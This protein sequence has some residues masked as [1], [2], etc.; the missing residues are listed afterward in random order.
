MVDLHTHSTASDGTLEPAELV[1]KAMDCGVKAL[2]L[3]DHDT[4][5]G[6]KEAAAQ[7]SELDMKFIPGIEISADFS[8]GTMHMLGYYVDADDSVLKQKLSWLREGR[9]R[10]NT[11]IL[12]MLEKQG[13]PVEMR[14]LEVYAKGESVGRPH[15]ARAMVAKGY[16]GNEE[17]AFNRFLAKGGPAY[18]NKERMN[19]TRAMELVIGAGGLPVLAH[20]QTLDL[21]STELADLLAELKEAGLAGVETYYFSHSEEEMFLYKHIADDLDLIVTGG[22]DY[23]GPGFKGIEL[24][25]GLGGMMVPDEVVDRLEEEH[26]ARSGS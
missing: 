14:E 21:N 22:T 18:A 10:R 11:L 13:Y 17:E 15:I 20:P 8:P 9:D 7:A 26:K 12:Q 1:R 6:L 24:G 23:H 4:L 16:V 5:S 3:T 25:R 19:P 2:S